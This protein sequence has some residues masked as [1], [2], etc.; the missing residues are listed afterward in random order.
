MFCIAQSVL[1]FS[2]NS[3]VEFKSR[4]STLFE[5]PIENIQFM[6]RVCDDT[7]PERYLCY[8]RG[9]HDAVRLF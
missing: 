5:E 3:R 4:M 1:L 9:C 6:K 8:S 7:D 2:L